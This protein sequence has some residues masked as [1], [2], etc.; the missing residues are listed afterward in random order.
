MSK[1][2]ATQAHV[3]LVRAGRQQLHAAEDAVDVALCAVAKLAITVGEGRRAV[4]LSAVVGQEAFDGIANLYTN[5]TQARRGAVDLHGALGEVQMQLGCGHVMGGPD[6]KPD[7]P[8]PH[9]GQLV[10]LKDVRAA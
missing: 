5:L 8:P 7:L 10:E 6:A 3:D 2:K 1:I 4:G 9:T